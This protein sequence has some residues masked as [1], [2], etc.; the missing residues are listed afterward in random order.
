MQRKRTDKEHLACGNVYEDQ[1]IGILQ[2]CIGY[3]SFREEVTLQH[4][5]C[6]HRITKEKM[7]SGLLA[8]RGE[9][10]A[11][12]SLNFGGV[13]NIPEAVRLMLQKVFK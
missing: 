10:V 12:G 6:H 2:A 7:R 3:D 8:Q 1:N 5:L 13:Y 9:V 4:R 11:F